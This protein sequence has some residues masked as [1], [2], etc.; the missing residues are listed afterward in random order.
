MTKSVQKPQAMNEL[1]PLMRQ[2]L[3]I[4]RKYPD[5]VL[6]YRM[7]DFY[8]TF[9]EDAKTAA[10]VLGITLTSRSNGKAAAT[11]LAG[12]PYHALESYLYKF[13]QAGYRVAICEQVEDPKLAKGIVKREVVEV[14]TPGTALSEQFLKAKEANFLVGIAREENAIGLAV[15]DVSTGSFECLE[16]E[17]PLLKSILAG[18]NPR[19]ILL[20]QNDD[21]LRAKVGNGR[22]LMTPMEDWIY[23]PDFAEA[24]LTKKFST[25][26]LKG[27]GLTTS[28]LAVQAAGVILYYL[29]TYQGRKLEHVTRIRVLPMQ[30]WMVLDQDTV[31]NLELF[32]TISGEGDQTLVT[33][34]DET[35]T[36]AGGRLLRDWL[37]KPLI[38]ESLI[39]QRL[40]QVELF[41]NDHHVC[42]DLRSVLRQADDIERLLAKLGSGRASGRDL[43]ALR[44][45]LNLLPEL[46]T[47]LNQHLTTEF[48]RH[49]DRLPEMSVMETRIGEMIVDEPPV[50]V[51][52]GGFIRDGVDADL[53]ES[54]GLAR[55]AKDWLVKYQKEERER[56]GIPSLKVS[57]NKVFGY[58]IDITHTHKERV[59]DSYMRKQTLVN[60]ERFITPE[61]KEYEEKVLGAEDRYTAREYEIFDA[62]RRDVL[63]EAA[64]FQA[65]AAGLAELDVLNTFAYV[66]YERDYVRPEINQST[67]IEI[68]AGRHPVIERLLPVEDSF[69]P[70]DLKISA[71]HDQILIITGPNMAGKSTYLRQIGL[72]VLMA[73]V[74][75]FVPARSAK[76]GL[77]DR[78][79]TRVGAADN[80]ARG[81]S[82]F[83]VEMNETANILNN[84][85]QR[86]LILLDEIG[87]GTST[88]DGLAIAWAIVEHLHAHSKIAART[89]FATHYHELVALEKLLERVKNYNMAVKEYGDKV[90]FLRKI[91]PGGADKSY[92]IHVAQMAGVPL[93]VIQRANEILQ[94]L[95]GGTVA[96]SSDTVSES[97]PSFD[98][99]QMSLFARQENRLRDKL[100]GID[101]N[102]LTPMQ[103][104]T[105]L[106]ELQQEVK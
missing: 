105:L 41:F 54:R 58:Y 11:P 21:N 106:D 33:A 90:I 57:Y 84:A 65:I 47:L 17:L 36:A 5:V 95:D 23:H 49:F 98:Q 96:V 70:N 46:R 89:L 1:T 104:L 88:Y 30:D 14:V 6:L 4:K 71:E 81:E 68:N 93:T 48:Q 69:I 77:V 34:L 67:T 45:T 60:S 63:N 99:N 3:E 25:K 42:D 94:S 50:S 87:R 2:Y 12:F 18:L 59:P 22:W 8:E 103:A 15:I 7:G 75:C 73:Q 43:V 39:N 44:R 61:L 72:I 27:F 10:K 62:L 16:T 53:D 51:K 82:T 85:T 79:F 64:D 13:M 35:V 86:S 37:H 101:L 38:N 55:N 78:I 66:A 91:I 52:E 40:A 9:D 102:H 92:G 56:L 31:R 19:E 26:N 32:R 29:Q 74:G 83:L 20:P 24:T 100:K 28:P 97:Q 76:I 80:L